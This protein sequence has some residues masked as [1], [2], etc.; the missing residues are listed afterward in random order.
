MIQRLTA[1]RCYVTEHR[2]SLLPAL[3]KRVRMRDVER[4]QSIDSVTE[5]VDSSVLVIVIQ[6]RF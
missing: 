4:L 5:G 1:T 3:S 2:R 6:R